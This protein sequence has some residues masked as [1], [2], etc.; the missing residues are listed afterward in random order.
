MNRVDDENTPSF[1]ADVKV[2]K[3]DEREKITSINRA[4][5][6]Q[7]KF[8]RFW[9]ITFVVNTVILYACYLR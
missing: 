7:S 1:S 4:T 2:E 5:L 9:F 3:L 8:V 6:L